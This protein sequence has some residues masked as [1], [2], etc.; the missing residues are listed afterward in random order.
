[1]RDVGQLAGYVL[2]GIRVVPAWG[3][4][5]RARSLSKD[6]S[7]AAHSLSPSK[8]LFPGPAP[9]DRTGAMRTS[10]NATLSE[11]R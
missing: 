8:V 6:T 5:V 3:L 2:D 11:G 9:P 4:G 7:G 1:M 10:E